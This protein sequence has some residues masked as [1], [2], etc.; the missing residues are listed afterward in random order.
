M[1]SLIG[2]HESAYSYDMYKV[3]RAT[4]CSARNLI[5]LLLAN[6]LHLKVFNTSGRSGFSDI[7]IDLDSVQ[8]KVDLHVETPEVGVLAW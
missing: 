3:S 6:K 4:S 1:V 7:Y 8:L 2:G 5:H